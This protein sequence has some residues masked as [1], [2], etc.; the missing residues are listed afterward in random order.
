ME[1][2]GEGI[3]PARPTMIN[4]Y[5][6]CANGI[7]FKKKVFQRS[8]FIFLNVVFCYTILNKTVINIIKNTFVLPIFF[9]PKNVFDGVI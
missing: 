3:D 1:Y 8:S 2:K 7:S 5:T 6:C 4:D 9:H